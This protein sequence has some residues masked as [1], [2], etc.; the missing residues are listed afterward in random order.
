MMIIIIM[1]T[2]TT[3]ITRMTLKSTIR[4]FFVCLISSMHH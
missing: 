2:T 1:I 4:G 3:T